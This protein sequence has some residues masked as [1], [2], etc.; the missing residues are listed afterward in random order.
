MLEEAGVGA[1]FK[2]R[3]EWAEDLVEDKGGKEWA[4]GTSL[5]KAFILEEE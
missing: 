4:E 5:G 2:F 1:K 3:V